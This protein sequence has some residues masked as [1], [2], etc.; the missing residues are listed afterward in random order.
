MD[1]QL[2]RSPEHRAG[3][4][5]HGFVNSAVRLRLWEETLGRLVSLQMKKFC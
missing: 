1:H 5:L 3:S 4:Q 2:E